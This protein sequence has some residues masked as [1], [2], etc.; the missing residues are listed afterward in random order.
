MTLNKRGLRAW[1]NS[2]NVVFTEEQKRLILDRF[3]SEPGDGN[4]WSEQDI[5]ENIRKICRDYP[6]CSE[7]SR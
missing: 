5:A 6:A 7:R 1:E 2:A 4:V 3:G